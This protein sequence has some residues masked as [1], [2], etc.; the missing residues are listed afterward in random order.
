M[1]RPGPRMP[2][3][4]VRMPEEEIEAVQV[5]AEREQVT[6]SEAARLMLAFSAPRM[7]EGWRPD[8]TL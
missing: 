4:S 2:H 6:R 5:I 8:G 1:P 7:P 3:L